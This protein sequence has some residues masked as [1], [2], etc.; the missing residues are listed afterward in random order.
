[1]LT[2]DF[3]AA[4]DIQFRSDAQLIDVTLGLKHDPHWRYVDPSG[5]IHRWTQ[6]GRLISVVEVI[7]AYAVDEYDGEKY[8]SQS[9]YECKR[10]HAVVEPGFREGRQMYVT[11]L[12]SQE[13][14]VTLPDL[15]LADTCIAQ[16]YQGEQSRLQLPGDMAC[17]AFITDVKVMNDGLIISVRVTG[18]GMIAKPSC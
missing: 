3:R 12:R 4:R 1:M 2:I 5:H 18:P 7:D 15:T 17:D 13:L 11:G 9:H 16:L 10:C 6:S 8:V 14:T